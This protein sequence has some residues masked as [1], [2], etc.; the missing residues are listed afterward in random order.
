MSCDD[1]LSDIRRQVEQ[2][3]CGSLTTACKILHETV[4][5]SA[6]KLWPQ[7]VANIDQ[8]K[9]EL[10]KPHCRGLDA[11]PTAIDCGGMAPVVMDFLLQLI[12][13]QAITD[14]KESIL[15][16]SQR[17]PVLRNSF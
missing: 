11:E 7:L 12:E 17:P 5:E 10:R 6:D 2:G 13:G 16:D 4:P 3:A 1:D 15:L 14:N 8:Y 9:Q